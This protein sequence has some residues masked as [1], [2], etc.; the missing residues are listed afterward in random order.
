MDMCGCSETPS[1]K[2]DRSLSQVLLMKNVVDS[3]E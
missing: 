2:R 3:G 1:V